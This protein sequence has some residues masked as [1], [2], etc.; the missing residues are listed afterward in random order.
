M[1]AELRRH[2]S[3]EQCVDI[4]SVISLFGWCNRWN[5]TF[6]N[7]LEI[8]PLKFAR[9]NPENTEHGWNIGDHGK[10]AWMR[11]SGR[12]SLTASEQHLGSLSAAPATEYGSRFSRSPCRRGIQLMLIQYW[13]SVRILLYIY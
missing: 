10:N 1:F 11:D 13:Q 7:V 8:V 9:Q 5:D 3:D 12:A 2:F 6:A 4:V